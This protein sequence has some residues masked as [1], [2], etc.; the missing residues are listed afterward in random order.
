[1]FDLDL[2]PDGPFAGAVVNVKDHGA[3]G[4]GATDDTAALRAA[5]AASHEGDAVYFP[6][7]TYLVSQPLR[8]KAHQVYFALTDRATLKVR[9]G[10]TGFVIFDVRSG[11]VAFHRL[12]LDLAKDETAAPQ[13]P[14][15]AS[16]IR[17]QSVAEGAADVV[18]SRC[19]IR[20]AHGHGIGVNSAGGPGR[21][22]VIVRDTVVAEC[23]LVGL[24]LG[25]VDHARVESSRFERCRNGILGRLCR[26]VVVRGVT[27]NENERHGIVFTFSQDWHVDQC[28]V[29]G[30]GS[31]TDGWGIAAGGDPQEPPP[32]PN[33]DFTITDN[34]CDGNASG[35]ITLDPTVGSQ[36]QVIQVQ[37]ARISGNVCRDA[38]LHHGINVTHARDVVVTDNVCAGNRQGC[39]IAVTS[40][41]HVLVQANVCSGNRNGIGLFNNEIVTDP[42]HYVIG[43]NLLYDNDVDMLHSGAQGAVLSDVRI[44]GAVQMRT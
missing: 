1:M 30:N 2:G 37:R 26:D 6:S 20:K 27:A 40:S 39:G 12:A 19:R 15:T 36:P 9:A 24:A 8:P 29:R 35:G 32:P 25:Q 10:V 14:R 43:V 7:G 44:H 13:D 42:G 4:D 21:D 22:R 18:V 31:G 41:S 34:L 38:V 11:P 5:I 17:V 16:G 23:G 3:S 33:H 28:V